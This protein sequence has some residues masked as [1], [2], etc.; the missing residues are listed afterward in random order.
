MENYP[1]K[2]PDQDCFS[3][4]LRKRKSR[5]R[6]KTEGD[7]EGRRRNRKGRRRGRKRRILEYKKTSEFLK[8]GS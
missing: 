5:N 4:G 8:A 6:R 2:L 1:R 3:K 7:G